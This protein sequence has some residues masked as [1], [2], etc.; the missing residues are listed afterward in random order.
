MAITAFRALPSSIKTITPA[1][2]HSFK[3][4]FIYKQIERVETKFCIPYYIN[5]KK[6][7]NQAY[8]GW[9][10]NEIQPDE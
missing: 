1:N 9:P 2:A 3:D 6:M 4:I 5:T 8:S 10:T 7:K